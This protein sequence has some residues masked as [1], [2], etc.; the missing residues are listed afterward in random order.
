MAGKH[1]FMIIHPRQRKAKQYLEKKHF[2]GCLNV[3]YCE[4]R[5]KPV[6]RRLWFLWIPHARANKNINQRCLLQLKNYVREAHVLKFYVVFLSSRCGFKIEGGTSVMTWTF[7]W[8]SASAMYC[9]SLPRTQYPRWIDRPT[10]IRGS[11][12]QDILQSR[13]WFESQWY[14]GGG[15]NKLS[16]V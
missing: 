14:L 3:E 6:D 7:N 11:P 10:W 5:Q 8:D 16:A 1:V 12:S 2:D 9:F 4:E 13:H 15:R